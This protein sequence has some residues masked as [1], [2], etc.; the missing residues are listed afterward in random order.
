M[1]YKLRT[2]RVGAER[3]QA[4]MQA[5]SQRDGPAFKINNDARVTLVGRF[6]RAT[7]IDE[8]P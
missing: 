1:I 3:Q 8:L 6:L 5:L 7:C 2:M 4:A